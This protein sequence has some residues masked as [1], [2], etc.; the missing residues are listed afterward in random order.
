MK[1]ILIYTTH[2]NLEEAKKISNILLNE[3]LIACANFFPIISSYSWKGSIE[4]SEEIAAI[5]KTRTDNWE[6][7]RDTILA[8][9]TYE[10]PCVIKLVEAESNDSYSSWIQSETESRIK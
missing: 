6:K 5:L 4:T 1:F 2:K 10:T 8:N 9:H 7:V 3:K